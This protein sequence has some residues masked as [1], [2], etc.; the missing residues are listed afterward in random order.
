MN[1]VANA[2]K[3]IRDIV[4][5]AN[6][7]NLAKYIKTMKLD[8]VT[9]A[10]YG[11]KDLDDKCFRIHIDKRFADVTGL[12]P[13]STWYIYVLQLINSEAK[14]LGINRTIMICLDDEFKINKGFDNS[15]GFSYQLRVAE[16][17][18]DLCKRIIDVLFGSWYDILDTEEMHEKALAT[19]RS[20][21]GYYRPDLPEAY[22]VS[23]NNIETYLEVEDTDEDEDEDNHDEWHGDDEDEAEPLVLTEETRAEDVPF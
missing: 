5:L 7:S 10:V 13:K 23:E 19:D 20:Q 21:T 9:V 3:N 4:E 8:P 18:K 6:A 17:G 14:K 22:R 2:D 1:L 12:I 15:I 11:K 16:G